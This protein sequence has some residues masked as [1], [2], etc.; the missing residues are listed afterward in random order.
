MYNVAKKKDL[1]VADRQSADTSRLHQLW[2]MS[3]L[4]AAMFSSAAGRAAGPLQE[5]VQWRKVSKVTD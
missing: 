3:R 2:A 4:S 1:L 5:V